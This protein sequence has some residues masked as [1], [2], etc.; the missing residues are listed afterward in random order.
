MDEKRHLTIAAGLMSIA[1]FLS[2]I[3]GYVKDMI[4]ARIFGASGLTDAFFV[5][6]RIPNLLREL[7]AEGSMSAAFVPVFTEYMVKNDKEEAKRIASIVF[8]FLL[9]ILTIICLLGVLLAPYIVSVIAPGFRP[10]AQKFALT[11]ELTRIMFPF[12]L[13]VSLA[14][15]SMGILNSLKSFFIPAVAPMFLN[16]STIAFALFVA[17][18]MSQPLFAIAVGVSVGGAVQFG[19]QLRPLIKNGFRFKLSFA[20]SHPALKRMLILL[21]PAIAGMGVAQI[22]IFLSTIF[23]SFLPDGSATYLY[24]AMRLIHFP[25][26]I[27]GVAMAMAVLPTLSGYAVKGETGK[28]RETFSFS[29]RLLFFIT[30][31]AMAGLIA[32]GEPIVNILFQRGHFT[33]DATAGTVYALLF[34]SSGLWAFVGVRVTASTFYSM[35][36]TRTPVKIAGVSILTNILFS[37]ILM[38]PLRHGGLALAN[39][40]GSAVNFILLFLALR[41][42]LGRVDGRNI[43]RSFVK[44][45][46]ASFLMGLTGWLA[47]KGNIWQESGRTIEKAGVLAGVMALSI[48]VYLLVMH[49][50]KSEEMK[51]LIKMYKE[52]KAKKQGSG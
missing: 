45:S 12:L 30:M 34:Y 20:F 37:L 2:R 22:N 18:E 9:L 24:Y 46:F 5:A 16:L 29:L 35:Q 3:S 11:I 43:L 47:I 33:Y 52:R 39:A 40:I 4:L 23:V 38:G 6:F 51:Y 17:P 28:L 36:D 14:A 32:L 48:G 19:V 26:G 21:G 41:K 15:L 1:T 8:T 50:T 49:L 42:K 25:I 27:F 7:F 10:D 31:P 44:I 13:F